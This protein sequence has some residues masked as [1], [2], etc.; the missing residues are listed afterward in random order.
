MPKG[1]DHIRVF[2]ADDPEELD[3]QINEE[4][5]GGA[6]QVTGVSITRSASATGELLVA[7]VSFRIPI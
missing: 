1:R 7:I 2:Q 5:S 3:R 6:Y 4:I